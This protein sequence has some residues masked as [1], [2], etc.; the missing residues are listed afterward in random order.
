MARAMSSLPVPVSPWMR[1]AQ[2]VA[3]T[4]LTSSRMAASF[5][6]DPISSEVDIG[7]SLDRVTSFRTARNRALDPIGSDV[8]ISRYLRGARRRVPEPDS[9]GHT[10]RWSVPTGFFCRELYCGTDA[11]V[12]ATPP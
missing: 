2:S 11:V 1:T 4:A 6:L 12:N 8:A 5:G 10:D 9:S 7:L 3:A